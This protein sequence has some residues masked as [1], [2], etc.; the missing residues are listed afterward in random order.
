MR[1]CVGG[2][3]LA[4]ARGESIIFSLT[5]PDGHRSTLELAG[6][7]VKKGLFSVE[8]ASI[9]Q[10]KSEQNR[11]PVKAHSDAARAL[12]AFLKKKFQAPQEETPAS[13]A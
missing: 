10:H 2:Y 8:L 11:K 5:S 1:H 12:S 3:A 7:N 9:V 4:V 13:S 6:P